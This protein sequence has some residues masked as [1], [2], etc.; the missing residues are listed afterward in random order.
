MTA[1]T[2]TGTVTVDVAPSLSVTVSDTSYVP[3][4]ANVNVGDG[5]SELPAEPNLPA[6]PPM[7]PSLSE[8]RSVNVQVRSTHADSNAAVGGAFGR[9]TVTV[10]SSESSRPF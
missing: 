7:V 10:I 5:T 9:L 3:G 6:H 2:S 1:W 4:P 8:L